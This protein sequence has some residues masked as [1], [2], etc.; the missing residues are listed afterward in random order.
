M[1]KKENLKEKIDFEFEQ[2]KKFIEL[3]K[4]LNK[5]LK[6]EIQE[7]LSNNKPIENDDFEKDFRKFAKENKI[8]ICGLEPVDFS[9]FRNGRIFYNNGFKLSSKISENRNIRFYIL[10]RFDNTTKYEDLFSIN[11][12]LIL[13]E[14]QK[15]E[16]ELE[17]KYNKLLNELEKYV[18]ILNSYEK[19]KSELDDFGVKF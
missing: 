10:T 18:K 11:K 17:I 6:L 19:V 3:E 12:K 7:N 14:I 1:I 5:F 16:K 15:S 2:S 4:K 8:V 13:S 9:D